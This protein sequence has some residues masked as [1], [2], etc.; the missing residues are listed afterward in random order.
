MLIR[1]TSLTEETKSKL[2]YENSSPLVQRPV[3]IKEQSTV[4]SLSKPP[5][6]RYETIFIKLF[7]QATLHLIFSFSII[8]LAIIIIRDILSKFLN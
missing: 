6:N 1:S 3:P 8:F 2:F 7:A 5:Q 4:N